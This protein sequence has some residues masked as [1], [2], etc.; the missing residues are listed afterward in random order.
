MIA[1]L[2]D[3]KDMKKN[4]FLSL[5][6]SFDKV[7]HTRLDSSYADLVHFTRRMNLPIHQWF[8]YQEGYSPFLVKKMIDYLS[9]KPG[10]FIFDPFAGSGTTLLVAKENK[11]ASLGLEIN[12]FSAFMAMVKTRNYS[13]NE[14]V[15]LNSFK[16]PS[17]ISTRQ[18]YKKYELSII[19]NLFDA[20]QLEKLETLK[21]EIRAVR[22]I[23]VRNLLCAALLCIL[24]PVSNYRKGG[25]GLKRKKVNKGLDAFAEFDKKKNQIFNDLQHVSV[26]AE[27]RIENDS[28]LNMDK[29]IDRKIDLAIFSPPYANCFDPFEVYKIELWLGEF[30]A[31]YDQL[32]SLRRRALTSNLNANLKKEMNGEHRSPLLAKILGSLSR[33]ALWDNRILTMIDTYFYDMHVL[34]KKLYENTNKNG[35]CIIVVGNSAYGN[36][37]VPTDILLAELGENIGFTVQEIIEGRKNE[38]SSQQHDKLGAFDAYVRE[39]LVVLK[40]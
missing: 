15:M 1:K 10:S 30:V 27:P 32:R 5:Y 9:V 28:C 31:S 3:Y 24:E 29:Y 40:K 37:A 36:L 22:N 4:E 39:S 6:K 23:K 34:L 35:S 8:Y 33:Q 20:N 21:K 11:C 38:T 18:S 25:N 7:F 13:N 19:R 2:D 12:P 17:K 26:G 16:T 14:I